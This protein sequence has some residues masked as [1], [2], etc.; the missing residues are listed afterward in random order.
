MKAL[1]AAD[2]LMASGPSPNVVRKT[3]MKAACL[4][5]TICMLMCAF[6]D[7]D[8][9]VGGLLLSSIGHGLGGFNLF[10]IGQTL[11]GPSATAKWIGLQ[12]CFGNISGIVAPVMTGLIVDAT[13]AY[14]SAFLLAALM[15]VIGLL[16]WTIGIRRI[17][18]LR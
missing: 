1:G 16:S 4:V 15:S 8:V 5:S 3:C 7:P 13:G 10:A 2:R 14:G 11:A 12:N 17:E 18:P 6:R 9:A